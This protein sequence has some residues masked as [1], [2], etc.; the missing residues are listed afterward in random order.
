MEQAGKVHNGAVLDDPSHH[1]VHQIAQHPA[2]VLDGLVS[3]QLDHAAQ[4]LGVASSW[5]MAVSK[6]T[7]VR[8]ED[9]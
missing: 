5:L 9:C 1:H 7:R 2:G 6:D 4:I 3:P 8:V